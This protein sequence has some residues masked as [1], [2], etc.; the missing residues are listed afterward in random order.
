MESAAPPGGVM[1]SDSSARMVEHLVTLAEPEWVQI[2]GV[3]EPVRAHLLLAIGPREGLVGR[4]E[5]SLSV[6]AGRWPSSRR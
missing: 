4:A 3:D 1:L 6:A 2:K 5:A